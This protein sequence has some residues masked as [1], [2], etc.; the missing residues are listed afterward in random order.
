MNL[1]DIKLFHDDMLAHIHKN[2]KYDESQDIRLLTCIN[3]LLEEAWEL[4]SIVEFWRNRKDSTK[5]TYNKEDAGDE[6]ADI[7]FV[8]YSFCE[9]LDIDLEQAIQHK[10]D[11]NRKKMGF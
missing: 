3:K 8:L 10:M 7:I 4:A 5:W 11:K 9:E 1:Q 2:Y 6:I